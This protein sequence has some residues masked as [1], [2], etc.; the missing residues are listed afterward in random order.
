MIFVL[1]CIETTPSHHLQRASRT[2]P[3][4][5]WPKAAEDEEVNSS[6][7]SFVSTSNGAELA[8]PPSFPV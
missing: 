2:N 8:T 6:M 7:V 4:S 5:G 1:C 3:S